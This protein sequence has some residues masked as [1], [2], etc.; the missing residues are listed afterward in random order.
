MKK[1]NEIET[2]IPLAEGLSAKQIAGKLQLQKCTV[3]NRIYKMKEK[4]NAKNSVHLIT[5]AFRLG[6]ITILLLWTTTLQAQSVVVAAQPPYILPNVLQTFPAK[7]LCTNRTTNWFS[8]N[9]A[10][11][12][13][14]FITL[15]G[16]QWTPIYLDSNK[17]LID[18]TKITVWFWIKK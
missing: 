6:L 9:N 4:Y 14:G 18:T 1:I 3:E 13:E 15:G 17:K 5:I 12:K 11:P 8:S 2:L 16:T 10:F 7:M